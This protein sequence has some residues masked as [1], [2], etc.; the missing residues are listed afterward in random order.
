MSYKIGFIL[1]MIFVA[2][3]FLFAGDMISLQ[4]I[5]SDLDA[6]SV[7]ISYLISENGVIDDEFVEY[8]ETKYNVDFVTADNYTP[9]F[10][11]EVTYIIAETYKP[12]VMSKDEMTIS[13]KR[14]T[15]IGYYH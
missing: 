7:T 12:L 13:V 8:I 2:M 15:V 9:L 11:D 5:Y 10:G 6:K 14:T 1:S 4:F 3:F